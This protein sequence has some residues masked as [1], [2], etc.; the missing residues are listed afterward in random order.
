MGAALGA[1]GSGWNAA[2]GI[3]GSYTL[4]KGAEVVG[5]GAAGRVGGALG[6]GPVFACL[7]NG[8]DGIGGAVLAIGLAGAYLGAS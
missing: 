4:A 5:T 8:A 6:G 2:V 3:A 1:T 7:A